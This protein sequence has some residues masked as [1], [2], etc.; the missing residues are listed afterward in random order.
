M[1]KDNQKG[2]SFWAIIIV[3]AFFVGALIVSFWPQDEYIN[4]TSLPVHLR[5]LK[6]AKNTAGE[7]NEKAKIEKWIVDNDLNEYGDS[8]DTIYAGGTPLYDEVSG[9]MMTRYEY[10]KK[11]HPSAPWNK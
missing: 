1:I 11:Q 9:K 4:D 2:V 6:S 8:M 7:L 10:I 5:I 3:V